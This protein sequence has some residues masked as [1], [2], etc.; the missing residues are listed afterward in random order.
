[1]TT[2]FGFMCPPRPPVNER[3]ATVIAGRMSPPWIVGIKN[4][5]GYRTTSEP[6]M[7]RSQSN[8]GRHRSTE[9]GAGGSAITERVVVMFQHLADW[10]VHMTCQ[11]RLYRAV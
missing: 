10:L 7:R 9:W 3:P 4:A 2:I 8:F 5:K 11:A 6:S 1:M